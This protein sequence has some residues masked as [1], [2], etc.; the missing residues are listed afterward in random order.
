MYVCICLQSVLGSDG[1]AQTFAE[2]SSFHDIDLIACITQYHMFLA[3]Y[4]THVLYIKTKDECRRQVLL[5]DFDE[6]SVV[7]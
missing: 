1:T 4:C 6:S 2:V 5:R 3:S 7:S